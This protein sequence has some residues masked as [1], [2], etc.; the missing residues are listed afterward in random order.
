MLLSE[1]RTLLHIVDDTVSEDADEDG[2]E[3]SLNN[4]PS[5]SQ[6]L[7]KIRIEDIAWVDDSVEGFL[8][9]TC[10]DVD[11][12]K[13]FSIVT[14]A[15]YD[16]CF[17]FDFECISMKQREAIVSA[18]RAISNKGEK[19][20]RM[21]RRSLPTFRGHSSTHQVHS[22]DVDVSATPDAVLSPMKRTCIYPGSGSMEEGTE[23][24]LNRTLLCD[25]ESVGNEVSLPRRRSV[26]AHPFSFAEVS[27]KLSLDEQQYSL[28][29][30]GSMLAASFQEAL[31]E[32]CSEDA[33]IDLTEMS[34]SLEGIFYILGTQKQVAANNDGEHGKH[35]RADS[36]EMQVASMCVT[37][38]LNTP[39]SI[40]ADLPS[41]IGS[42]EKLDNS[43]RSSRKLR[44]RAS[45][46]NAQ[47]HR[48][49]KLQTEMTFEAVNQTDQSLMRTIATTKSLDDLDGTEGQ[50]ASS[51]R[52]ASG[53]FTDTSGYGLFELFPPGMWGYDTEDLLD[54][55]ECDFYDS[56]PECSRAHTRGKGRIQAEKFNMAAAEEAK[57]SPRLNFSIPRHLGSRFDDEYASAIIDVSILHSADSPC[58]QEL[59]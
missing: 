18:L 45:V 3:K 27:Q 16:G 19:S 51:Q 30:S 26:P 48:W 24:A 14:K 41:P 42:D 32:W 4:D 17:H 2:E 15:A 33:C 53:N 28:E 35:V 8:S 36:S 49:R 46:A 43:T 31:D 22:V 37:D 25:D 11:S 21:R 55:E 5:D 6:L 54:D 1:D 58:E 44:N 39:A 40:W 13:C 47:A 7:H 50:V 59:C 34:E 57:K 52:I 20:L 12:L 9:Q 56:D 29:A 10:A 38:F 23:L